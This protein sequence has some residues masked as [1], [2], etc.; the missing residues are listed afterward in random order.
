M[1]NKRCTVPCALNLDDW[2]ESWGVSV[3]AL[4]EGA[5]EAAEQLLSKQPRGM[6]GNL[7]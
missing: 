1:P 5:I 4:E 2:D 6:S 3:E 7:S